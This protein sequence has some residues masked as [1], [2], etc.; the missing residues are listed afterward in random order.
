MTRYRS[1]LGRVLFVVLLSFLAVA[2]APAGQEFDF[3]PQ[4]VNVP[5]GAFIAGSDRLERELAYSVD[6]AA[7]AHKA[8]RTGKGY[9]RERTRQQSE[10]TAFAIARIPFTNAQYAAF[11]GAIGHRTL[12]V[13][14]D[15]WNSYGLIHPFERTALTPG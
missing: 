13:F 7:Y 4:P 3:I 11:V 8:T 1:R 14:L 10:T 9:E 15:L 12:D 2:R 5:A 6:A